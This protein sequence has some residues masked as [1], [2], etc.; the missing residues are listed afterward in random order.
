MNGWIN[1]GKKWISRDDII[2]L[3]I[4]MRV[5]EPGFGNIKQGTLSNTLIVLY[6]LKNIL[7]TKYTTSFTFFL[8]K[9]SFQILHQGL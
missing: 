1:I 4:I 3:K 8:L 9:Q 5:F 7:Y 2:F 6:A